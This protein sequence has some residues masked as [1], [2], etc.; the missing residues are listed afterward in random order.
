[1]PKK[2]AQ[3]NPFG[4]VAGAARSGVLRFAAW[5]Y[6]RLTTY[7][8]CPRRARYVHLEKRPEPKSPAM[9]RGTEIH[10]EAELYLKGTVR[11]LPAS[12]KRFKE[13]FAYLRKVKAS[14][15]GELAFDASWRPVSWFAPTVRLR[16]KI[17]ALA[18][19]AGDGGALLV[20]DYKTGKVRPANVDQ[21][22][23]YDAAGLL[24]TGAPAVESRL[25]FLDHGVVEPREPRVTEAS[26][27]PAM[28]KKWERRA[29]PMLADETHAPRPG[30]YCRWC[31]FRKD[32]GGPCE[33]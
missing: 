28:K 1:M 22:D 19:G 26:S 4:A 20:V 2:S 23:L 6:S 8:E 30:N 3:P 15:E 14:A 29:A 11:T 18:P 27:L 25:W 24:A 21:L 17:D 12:L 33:Y 10:K 9:D 16:V 32:N 13:G 5:S 31:H 7:E